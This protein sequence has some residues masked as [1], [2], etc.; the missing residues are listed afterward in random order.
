MVPGEPDAG[1]AVAE[2]R[3]V[4]AFEVVFGRLVVVLL[5]VFVVVGGFVEVVTNYYKC[6]FG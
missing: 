5:L 2:G 6:W 1:F 4:V 3:V